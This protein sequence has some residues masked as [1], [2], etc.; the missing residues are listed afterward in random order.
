MFIS[1]LQNFRVAQKLDTAAFAAKVGCNVVV[2][3][4]IEAGSYKPG[5]QWI[6][7][8]AMAFGLDMVKAAKICGE[9]IS[10][11]P[12]KQKSSKASVSPRPARRKSAP[13]VQ[14]AS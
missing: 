2:L 13:V 6:E 12:R 1:H 11:R 10:S 3:R 5:K 7:K 14:S 9:S 4:Q 8:F